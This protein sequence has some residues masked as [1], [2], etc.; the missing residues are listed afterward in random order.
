MEDLFA[1]QTLA[2]FLAAELYFTGPEEQ[3]FLPSRRKGQKKEE[4]SVYSTNSLE[5]I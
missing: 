1:S 3:V 4:I 2:T 5:L